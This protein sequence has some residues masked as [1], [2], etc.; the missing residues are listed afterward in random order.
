[1]THILVSRCST[2]NSGPKA[3]YFPIIG[4]VDLEV[5]VDLE[6]ASTSRSKSMPVAILISKYWA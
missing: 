1:M 3:H 6:A 4:E 2:E 5:E